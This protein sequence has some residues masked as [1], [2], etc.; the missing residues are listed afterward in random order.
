MN[1]ETLQTAIFG[2]SHGSFVRKMLVLDAK[3]WLAGFVLAF[4]L[5]LVIGL[6]WDLRFIALGCMIVFLIFPMCMAYMYYSVGLTPECAA[7]VSEHRLLFSEEG[8]VAEIYVHDDDDTQK[9]TRVTRLE[10]PAHRIKRCV[11]FPDGV[12]LRVREGGFLWIPS[13]AL[14]STERLGEAL[15]PYLKIRKY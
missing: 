7:N 11:L 14:G 8:I 1:D 9:V 2:M 12:A 4:L 10:V 13:D 5:C 6:I 15:E 3:W